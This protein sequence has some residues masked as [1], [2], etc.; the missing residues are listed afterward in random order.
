MDRNVHLENNPFFLSLRTLHSNVEEFKKLLAKSQAAKINGGG[1][2]AYQYLIAEVVLSLAAFVML[3]SI[4]EGNLY[5]EKVLKVDSANSAFTFMVYN[6]KKY[7]LKFQPIEGKADNLTVD[8]I[9]GSVLNY[10]ADNDI[11]GLRGLIGRCF[12]RYLFSGCT[13]FKKEQNR[14]IFDMATLEKDMD[15]MIIRD[16]NE[17]N[18]IGQLL[19]QIKFP[20]FKNDIKSMHRGNMG[21]LRGAVFEAIDGFTLEKQIE[22]QLNSISGTRNIDS[23]VSTQEL[24]QFILDIC[25]LGLNTGFV[26]NDA[27]LN[28]ILWDVTTRSYKYIDLGRSFFNYSK[29]DDDPNIAMVLDNISRIEYLKLNPELYNDSTQIPEIKVNSETETSNLRDYIRIMTNKWRDIPACVTVDPYILNKFYMLN[30]KL[31]GNPVQPNEVSQLEHFKKYMF[32][33]D[34]MTITMNIITF[35]Y[36]LLS[37][38]EKT[39]FFNDIGVSVL[40]GVIRIL[41]P[42]KII[43]NTLG[44]VMKFLGR[45]QQPSDVFRKYNMYILGVLTFSIFFHKYLIAHQ[46]QDVLKIF[47]TFSKLSDLHQQTM[48]LSASGAFAHIKFREFCTNTGIMHTSFQIK[49]VPNPALLDQVL[50]ENE[51]N[52]QS[53][54]SV[55]FPALSPINID[56]ASLAAAPSA[57][58]GG[59]CAA[60]SIRRG[61]PAG[62]AEPLKPNLT[63]SIDE[64]PIVPKPDAISILESM[65]IEVPA[66]T[67]KGLDESQPKEDI[68][69]LVDAYSNRCA[70]DTMALV[71]EQMTKEQHKH[72]ICEKTFDKSDS[73]KEQKAAKDL[74]CLLRNKD[75]L[76]TLKKYFA[77]DAQ[78]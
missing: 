5:L 2:K 34:V 15:D 43:E 35:L 29:F 63:S 18:A 67:K 74:A 39:A 47:P 62:L 51:S 75:H 50:K 54:M 45:V 76:E 77:K 64:S 46:D 6:Q 14:A 48:S 59:Y 55:I 1:N 49:N 68:K 20:Y 69:K 33:F 65:G 44:I 73:Q 38:V 52:I 3:Y 61:M 7:F 30:K 26:H 23:V 58:R 8:T 17:S 21:L 41:K 11:L 40:N 27:H 72:D 32:L 70:V 19:Q 60:K 31:G 13:Y 25:I 78:I 36:P 9:N 24:Y 53:I 66:E 42:E 22:D 12:P 37:Q 28:N 4:I 16:V 57:Q 10:L 71:A 56:F